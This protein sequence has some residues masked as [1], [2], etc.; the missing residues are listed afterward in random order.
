M[1]PPVRNARNHGPV[2]LFIFMG[3]QLYSRPRL[4]YQEPPTRA[5][6][7][8]YGARMEGLDVKILAGHGTGRQSRFCHPEA[9][10]VSLVCKCQLTANNNHEYRNRK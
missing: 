5:G 1:D 7:P 2:Y 6:T 9:E 3:L 10:Q 8:V 4:T